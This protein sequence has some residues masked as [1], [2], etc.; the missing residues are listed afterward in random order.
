MHIFSNA[1]YKHNKVKD[2]GEKISG[3]NYNKVI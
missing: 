3:L 2:H 1:I